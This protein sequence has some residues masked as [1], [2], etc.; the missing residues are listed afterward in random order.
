M[1][2]SEEGSR[3]TRTN[4][5]AQ[6]AGAFLSVD[7]CFDLQAL[8]PLAFRTMSKRPKDYDGGLHVSKELLTILN[9]PAYISVPMGSQR[10]RKI[11]TEGQQLVGY[12]A[13]SG[14]NL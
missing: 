11:Y 12:F 9:K 4:I 14:L 8:K 6:I 10:A 2:G 7:P 3:R 13:D 1:L 5:I